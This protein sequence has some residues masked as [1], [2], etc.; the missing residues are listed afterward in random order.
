MDRLNVQATEREERWDNN[1]DGW[2]SILVISLF[3]ASQKKIETK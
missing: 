1:G 3:F 2:R